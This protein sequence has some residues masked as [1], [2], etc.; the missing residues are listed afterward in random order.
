MFDHVVS[1]PQEERSKIWLSSLYIYAVMWS[2]IN[3]ST[4][5]NIKSNMADEEDESQNKICFEEIQFFPIVSQTN[6]YGLT[7]FSESISGC[8]KV[9][10]ASLKGKISSI[11]PQRSA[12]PCLLSSLNVPFENLQG[13]CEISALNYIQAKKFLL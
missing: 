5:E 11:S 8:N 4:L 10:L 12:R 3:Q 2:N 6:V 1:G 7:T 13:R 9:L